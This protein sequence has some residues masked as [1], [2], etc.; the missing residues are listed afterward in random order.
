MGVI[1]KER[2]GPCHELEITLS[3]FPDHGLSTFKYILLII[4]REKVPFIEGRTFIIGGYDGGEL[5][6]KLLFSKM[7]GSLWIQCLYKTA[8]KSLAPPL[9]QILTIYQRVRQIMGKTCS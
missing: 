8:G 2:E 6:G 7:I 9:P 4:G 3:S 1:C 5:K